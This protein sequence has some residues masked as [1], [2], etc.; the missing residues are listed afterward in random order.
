M[1]ITPTGLLRASG[2]GAAASGLLFALIQ[3]I[4]PLETVANVD[5]SAWV[6]THY[7]GIL[8]CV[9]GLVGVTGMYLRQVR[10]AGLLGL[11][12]Y[13]MFCSFFVLTAGFQF[14]EAFALPE[15]TDDAPRL[16]TYLLGVST[17]KDTGDLGAVA[18]IAP[19]TGVLYLAGG[20]GFAISLYRARI[21][22]RWASVVLAAGTTVTL[23]APAV[24]HSIAR[25]FAFPVAVA[26]VGL[27]LSL[28]RSGRSS[29]AT[30]PAP[31]WNLAVR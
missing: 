26:M 24:P 8:M 27:G 4:H 11:V 21:L 7:L 29:A 15:M 19:L 9:L 16:V 23:A 20:L 31:A 22:A 14:I 18:A 10:E 25:M 30:A 6:G 5:T 1:T 17:G 12:A 3:F 2:L 13:L 28:W